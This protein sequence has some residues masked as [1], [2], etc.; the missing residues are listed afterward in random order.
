MAPNSNCE[1]ISFRIN[2][3]CDSFL[4]KSFSIASN[5]WFDLPDD[6]TEF[7]LHPAIKSN[8]RFKQNEYSIVHSKVIKLRLSNIAFSKYR[9][10]ADELRESDNVLDLSLPLDESPENSAS[11]LAEAVLNESIQPP[12]AASQPAQSLSPEVDGL[13]KL[14]I[15][16]AKDI[17]QVA[18]KGWSDKIIDYA[19]RTFTAKKSYASV[20]SRLIRHTAQRTHNE[21][22]IVFKP[23]GNQTSEQIENMLAESSSS[24]CMRNVKS[25]GGKVVKATAKATESDELVTKLTES[26]PDITIHKEK[27]ISPSIILFRINHAQTEENV[28]EQLFNNNAAISNRFSFE[29]FKKQIRFVRKTKPSNKNFSHFIF[30]VTS[31]FRKCIA[32]LPRLNID[33]NSLIWDDTVHTNRCFNCQSY[34]HKSKDCKKATACGSCGGSHD[35]KICTGDTNKNCILCAKAGLD[36]KHRIGSRNCQVE[37]LRRCSLMRRVDFSN[38]NEFAQ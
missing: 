4:V 14:L 35:I 18:S 9:D 1:D 12:P 19:T 22:T 38:K 15:E 26:F 36:S 11:L 17:P 37:Q 24:S 32:E 31:N 3:H 16:M 23:K 34:G 30:R 5:E 7:N 33:N 8:A 13:R 21:Q 27:K 2:R 6:M 10:L 29:E 28:V 25:F 20:A